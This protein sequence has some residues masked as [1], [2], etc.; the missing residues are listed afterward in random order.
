MEPISTFLKHNFLIQIAPRAV[1]Y[2]HIFGAFRF[3][4]DFFEKTGRYKA[5]INLSLVIAFN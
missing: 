1:T 2:F 5:Q 4:W 3:Y